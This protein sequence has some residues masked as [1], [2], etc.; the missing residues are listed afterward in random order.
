MEGQT[1]DGSRADIH[2]FEYQPVAEYGR[3]VQQTLRPALLNPFI[4]GRSHTAISKIQ[5]AEFAIE[6]A[7]NKFGHFGFVELDIDLDHNSYTLTC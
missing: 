4:N 1:P 3:R 5:Q 2:R 7:E 6:R